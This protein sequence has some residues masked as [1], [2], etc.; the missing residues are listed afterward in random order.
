MNTALAWNS[1]GP[2]PGRTETEWGDDAGV[3]NYDHNSTTA[4]PYSGSAPE[5]DIAGWRRVK[6][7]RFAIIPVN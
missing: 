4:N 5:T 3:G 6:P 2:S 7:G 1:D